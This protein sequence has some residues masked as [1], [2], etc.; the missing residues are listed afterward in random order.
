[1]NSALWISA[2]G[3][4]LLH[5]LWQGLCIGA[6]CAMLLRALRRAHPRVRYALCALA[7]AAC[8]ALPLAHTLWLL[9]P[10]A[11]DLDQAVSE[12]T[13]GWMLALAERLPLLVHAWACGVGL[14]SSRLALGL[15]WLHTLRRSAR[16]APPEWQARLDVLAHRLGLRRPVALRLLDEPAARRAGNGPLAL[17]TRRPLVLLPVRL[18]KTWPAA[19]LEALLAHELAHVRRWDYAA[20]LLQSAAEALLFFHPVVWWLSHR[21]RRERELV[22]D[23]LATQ[24]LGG[25]RHRL[26]A[27]LHRLSEEQAAEPDA[28]TGITA[29]T[30][31][32]ALG[33]TNKLTRPTLAPSARGG[34]LLQ[35]IERLMTPS[36]GHTPWKFALPAL[37][38]AALTVLMQ[39]AGLDADTEAS[40]AEAAASRRVT[41][42]VVD[43]EPEP[44]TVAPAA[45]AA[46]PAAQPEMQNAA[47]PHSDRPFL[48]LPINARHVV[49][50]DD[51]HG[52]VLLAKDADAVVPIASLTKLVTAM[53]VLD[54]RQ[55]MTE[56]LRIEADDVDRVKHSTSRLAVGARMTRLD[57]LEM[58]LV[59]SENRAASALG[60]SYP[61]GLAAFA[62]AAQ[63]KLSSLGLRQT[64]IV[65]PTGLSPA[66]V[67]TAREMALIAMAAGRYRDIQRISSDKV[68][69][70]LVNG[71]PREVRNTNRL[72][73]GKGWDIR[74]SKT[75]YTEEAGRCLT[76]RLRDGGRDITVVL[77]DAD[78]SAHR[79]RDA[80][81]IRKHLAQMAI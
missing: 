25:D 34:H 23:D 75:G 56:V 78:G 16:P 79:L 73:G 69:S 63:A 68:S 36:P 67:S 47:Q 6:V 42:V 80:S 54:A 52:Q 41:G 3:W 37:A 15:W 81:L 51:N 8:V 53:V 12:S 2:L 45:L 55:D 9:Q 77:L 43:S 59:A 33:T 71:R 44:N 57:A 18:L 27:A 22:A 65:E 26:A 17:G 35:R 5:A 70:V 66:N 46:T 14:M 38:L 1:M 11:L 76:M 61:G 31:V 62:Q 39:T 64:H 50:M 29:V 48:Q 4:A 30:A 49:V 40:R 7:L 58:A 72:V 24:A 21:M 10:S 74:L 60:R 19:A 20:N 28:I 32:I 13:P